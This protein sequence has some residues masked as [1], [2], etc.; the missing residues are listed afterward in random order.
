MRDIALVPSRCRALLNSQRLEKL[1]LKRSADD[2]IE[3]TDDEVSLP[4][5]IPPRGEA[6]SETPCPS[7]AEGNTIDNDRAVQYEGEP[8][9]ESTLNVLWTGPREL[10]SINRDLKS[11]VH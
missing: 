8:S 3:R 4:I 6:N 1:L 10:Q 9:V 7:S 11:S 2:F 5:A